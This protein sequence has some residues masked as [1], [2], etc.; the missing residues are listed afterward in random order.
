MP[1]L[2][3]LSA[4]HAAILPLRGSDA[5]MARAPMVGPGKGLGAVAAFPVTSYANQYGSGN[6]TGLIAVT[7][8]FAYDAG[9][10]GL[11]INGDIASF[12]LDEPGVGSSPV[13]GLW[14]QFTFPVRQAMST[15]RVHRTGGATSGGPT[16]FK[17]QYAP[18]AGTWVDCCLPY[19]IVGVSP[20]E[21]PAFFGV[22]PEGYFAWRWLGVSGNWPNFFESE[23]E[24]KTAPGVN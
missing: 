6:R 15:A 14:V 9:A 13:A 16:L 21:A 12:E 20:V 5:A 19:N 22:E 23:A 11:M 1:N 7:A 18:V 17:W 24:F 3:Q 2:V 4:P 8:N 10:L